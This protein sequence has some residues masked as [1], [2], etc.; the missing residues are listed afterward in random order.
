[1]KQKNMRMLQ[2]LLCA[3]AAAALLVTGCGQAPAA[4]SDGPSEPKAEESAAEENPAGQPDAEPAVS[5]T[6]AAAEE[7]PE[8]ERT[9][10]TVSVDWLLGN[11]V[12]SFFYEE[13]EE[14]P[15]AKY[16]L[17]HTW[18]VDDLAGT[19]VVDFISPPAGSENDHFNT[20]MATNELPDVF[21]LARCSETAA[22]LYEENLI[23]DLSDYIQ[24]YMPNYT[25][26]LDANPSYASQM[27]FG[28]KHLVLFEISDGPHEAWDGYV[29]R[30]DW[31]AQ[32]GKNPKTGEPFTGGWTD[33]A[34]TTWEDDVVFPSGGSDPIYISDWEWMFEIFDEAMADLGI[35]DGYAFQ[36]YY[37]GFMQTGDL[38]S[39]F[40]GGCSSYYL[41]DGKATYGAKSDNFR[42][43][44]QC[45]NHWYEEGWMNQNFEENSADRM[46]T[47]VDTPTVFAGKVGL[48]LGYTHQIGNELDNGGEFTSGICVYGARQPINDIYGG[49]EQ[50]NKE[51]NM[52][53]QNSVISPG[54]C[55]NASIDKEKLPVLM[56][57]MDY[58]Y[59]REGSLL[60]NFGF[61]DELMHELQDPF[62]L[63]YNLPDGTYSIT[64]E[65][66]EEIIHVNRD[67]DAVDGLG[68][69]A[70]L[71]RVT[72]LTANR[73]VD[74]GYNPVQA[75]GYSEVMA[76]QATAMI[77][78]QVTAQLSSEQSTEASTITANL[79]TYLYQAV[80]DFITGRKD[81]DDDA[82]WQ[83]YCNTVEG[84]GMQR[85][86]DY[87]NEVLGN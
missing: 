37:A 8:A 85:Y 33:E 67:R 22:Q 58:L 27:T 29:Y 5:E 10:V 53:Y 36:N 83:D 16:W 4:N 77:G 41:E 50:Q 62:Y 72:G 43:F 49:P 20:L 44:L 1:M 30:R 64:K 79:N 13:Y 9:P 76:Y 15:A 31:I 24:S 26:W 60:R 11:G 61:S 56:T 52:F 18:N 17:S 47:S 40:G 42:A 80:P 75:H 32:Y 3:A 59:S 38:V 57:A 63:E 48:W 23:L 6:D 46:F 55:I 69:A 86:V 73:N 70:D 82:A 45:M 81:I 35:T 12:D 54:M 7:T 84:M 39:G 65:D 74:Q 25:A 66:G 78:S 87:I 34:H 2:R 21:S 14:N 19:L 51:P 68:V 71:I 28:G